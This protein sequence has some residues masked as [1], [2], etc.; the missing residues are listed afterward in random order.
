MRFGN[1]F[2]SLFDFDFLGSLRSIRDKALRCEMELVKLDLNWWL[3]EA[4][5]AVLS[6]FFRNL[7]FFGEL[8]LLW[9]ESAASFR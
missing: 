4:F 2:G 6:V 8:A 5:E 9:L 1:F 7:C 3:Y